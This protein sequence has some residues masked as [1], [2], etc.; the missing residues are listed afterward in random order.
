TGPTNERLSAWGP[1]DPSAG[2]PGGD[3]VAW[4]NLFPYDPEVHEEHWPPVPEGTDVW[5][6]MPRDPA[7]LIEYLRAQSVNSGANDDV[8]DESTAMALIAGLAGN[9]APAD[10]RAAY[11]DALRLSGFAQAVHEDGDTITFD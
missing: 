2:Q 10:L 9:D 8:A 1:W 3:I 6:S 5:K 11:L 7:A 4:D